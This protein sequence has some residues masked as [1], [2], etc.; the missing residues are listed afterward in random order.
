MTT[1]PPVPEPEPTASAVGPSFETPPPPSPQLSGPMRPSWVLPTATGV[2]G[3][4]I[5][6]GAMAGVS[7]SR[8]AAVERADQAAQEAADQAAADAAAVRAAVLSGAVKSCGLSSATG[9][10]LG[11]GGTSLTFDMKG[12]D[13][14]SGASIDDVACI[15]ARLDMPSAVLSHIDQTTSMDGR[16]TETWDNLTVSWSYHPDRGLDGVLTVAD[17]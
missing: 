6:A 3:L 15:F 17:M 10:E 7:A 16:Q 8:A 5:G 11:D 4:L 2:L 13:D 9:L 12:K 14:S 1:S